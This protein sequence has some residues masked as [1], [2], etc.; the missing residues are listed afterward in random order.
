MKLYLGCI[1][2][3]RLDNFR[4]RMISG[5]DSFGFWGGLSGLRA[6][7]N[8]VNI[9]NIGAI[10]ISIVC[11]LMYCNITMIHGGYKNIRQY[12]KSSNTYVLY[13]LFIDIIDKIFYFFSLLAH[14]NLSN[15]LQV[16][17]S[18]FRNQGHQF[19][20]GQTKMPHHSYEEIKGVP[21]ILRAIFNR[22]FLVSEFCIVSKFNFLD[23]FRCAN[24]QK[25]NFLG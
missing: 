12:F 15:I 8:V 18:F 13:W 7:Y 1:Q 21:S 22:S 3:T 24:K 19:F 11:V 6:I 23:K 20:R 17:L 4:T 5:G 14:R 2:I 16:I 10:N 9:L 25:K